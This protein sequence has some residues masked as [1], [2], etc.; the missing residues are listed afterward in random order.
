[1]RNPWFW[2]RWKT[3]DLISKLSKPLP[4]LCHAT[5]NQY[6]L[7]LSENIF[8]SAEGERKRRTHTFL[9]WAFH[10][11]VNMVLF[12]RTKY[13]I[14]LHDWQDY[15]FQLY[16]GSEVLTVVTMDSSIFWDI[17]PC[18]PVKVNWHFRGSLLHAG[19]CLAYSSTLKMVVQSFEMSSDFHMAL[20]P[21][22]QN[23]SF[24]LYSFYIAPKHCQISQDLF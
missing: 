3:I 16:T 23:S 15:N 20:H 5:K 17:M 13:D 19:F 6:T 12:I 1:M 7:T 10:I 22:K 8:C 14:L 21:R 2:F 18:N 24:Q 4:T 11:F 9:P